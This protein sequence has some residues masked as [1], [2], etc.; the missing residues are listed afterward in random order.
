MIANTPARR[1]AGRTENAQRRHRQEWINQLRTG[2]YR[3]GFGVYRRRKNDGADEFCII[4]VGLDIIDNRVWATPADDREVDYGGR[5]VRWGD[6]SG[7]AQP[8]L[9]IGQYFGLAAADY[10]ELVRTNDDQ[11][12]S[13]GVLADYLADAPYASEFQSYYNHLALQEKK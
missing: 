11:E 2:S 7:R 12:A 6:N 5:Q 4:G 3:Q 9:A 10:D 8:T 1:D 13:F